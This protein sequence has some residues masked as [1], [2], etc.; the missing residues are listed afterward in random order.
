MKL[1]KKPNLTEQEQEAIKLSKQLA[2][3]EDT[4]PVEISESETEDVEVLREKKIEAEKNRLK[5]KG[6]KPNEIFYYFLI[7]RDEKLKTITCKYPTTRQA[8]KYSKVLMN[9]ETQRMEFQFNDIVEDFEKDG[10]LVKF[11]IEDYD[12]SEITKL[13]VFLSGVVSNPRFK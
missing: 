1:D 9:P 4:A 13:A 10:L 6:L 2:G 7:D 5:L 8:M 12:V 3:V 11:D